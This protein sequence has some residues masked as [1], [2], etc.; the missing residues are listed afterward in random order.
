MVAGFGQVVPEVPQAVR[1]LAD[2]LRT[3]A[4]RAGYSGVRE[5][6]AGTGIG[7]TTI[8]D[9]FTGRRVPTWQTLAVLLRGCDVTPDR[10]WRTVYDAARDA[11]DEEKR[12]IRDGGRPDTDADIDAGAEAQAVPRRPA[13]RAA[14]GPSPS[15]RR[16]GSC[17]PESAAVTSCWTGWRADWPRARAG[18][19]SSSAWAAAARPPWR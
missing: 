12:A 8:S 18:R 13:G 4:R 14:P 11:V 5:L 9:A 6:A 16:T 2:R 17:R 15:V 19:R 10:A 7:R 1:D 3:V